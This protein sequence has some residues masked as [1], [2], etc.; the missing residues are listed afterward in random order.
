MF[1]LQEASALVLEQFP[2]RGQELLPLMDKLTDESLPPALFLRLLSIQYGEPANGF[3]LNGFKSVWSN[4]GSEV[5]TARP[6]QEQ[7]VTT[8]HCEAQRSTAKHSQ[9]QPGPTRHILGHLCS[10]RAYKQTRVCWSWR[11]DNARGSQAP[12]RGMFAAVAKQCRRGGWF[13][14]N[15]HGYRPW[16]QPLRSELV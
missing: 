16:Q 5:S 9:A 3:L 15:T 12:G 10:A 1:S 8:M 2:S 13:G 14:Q 6:S 11:Q 4:N 7:P